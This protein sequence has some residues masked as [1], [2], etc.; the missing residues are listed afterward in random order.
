[1]SK[2]AAP[3]SCGRGSWGLPWRRPWTLAA[4][5]ISPWQAYCGLQGPRKR[6]PTR[7]VVHGPAVGEGC[8]SQGAPW[9]WWVEKKPRV[10]EAR[11][12]RGGQPVYSSG[13]S[14]LWA[15]PGPLSSP[16]VSSQ[17][18]QKL[19]CACVQGPRNTVQWGG[20]MATTGAQDSGPSG[21]PEIRDR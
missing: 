17:A 12:S 9:S 18:G 3:R 11:C 10:T 13:C 21:V 4:V 6:G 16:P 5:P 14:R 7:L 19:R 2:T 8:S 1:M 15:G 20:T